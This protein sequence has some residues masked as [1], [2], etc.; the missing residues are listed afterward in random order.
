M[1]LC[2]P[3]CYSSAVYACPGN[4][5]GKFK[6]DLRRVCQDCRQNK[7]C[8]LHCYSQ[9]P[10][11]LTSA[12][13][14]RGQTSAETD[15][16]LPEAWNRYSLCLHW[17]SSKLCLQMLSQ[18]DSFL[19]NSKKNKI[20]PGSRPSTCATCVSEIEDNHYSTDSNHLNQWCTSTVFKWNLTQTNAK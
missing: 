18:S 10:Q 3:P 9:D 5:A 8:C 1:I 13:T 11:A 15:G 20:N 4:D 16:V 7:L 14:S 17:I 2:S 6:K 12:S 19:I